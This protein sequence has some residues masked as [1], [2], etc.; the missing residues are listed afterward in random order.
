[1]AHTDTIAAC[2]PEQFMNTGRGPPPSAST[3][4]YPTAIGRDGHAAEIAAPIAFL[5]S[6]AASL[7]VGSCLY[8]DGG[9][10]AILHPIAPEGWEVGPVE[11]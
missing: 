2:L 8:V 9:T 5:L 3:T 10:D 4:A 7:V 11:V 6:D 1:M